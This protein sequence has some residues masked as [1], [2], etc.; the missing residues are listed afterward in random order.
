[1]GLDLGEVRIGV[2]LSDP[3][4]LFA[5]AHGIIEEN[6][7]EKRLNR[8]AD[9]VLE[10]DIFEI[11][12]GY[13]LHLDGRKSPRCLYTDDM[14]EKM[15]DRFPDIKITPW[16]ERLST[17]E[18]SKKLR[19]K[20]PNMTHK[21]QKKFIDAMSAQVILQRFLN[22]RAQVNTDNDISDFDF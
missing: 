7:D 19:E 12:V 3:L 4:C 9:I 5:T 16:D 20:N 14:M 18:A 22:H 8:I 2:A 6:N 15:R 10:H 13:P 1:M 17:V 21:E 11:V